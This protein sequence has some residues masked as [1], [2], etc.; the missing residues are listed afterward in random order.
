MTARRQ[1]AEAC[2]LDVPLSAN[3]Y[4]EKSIVLFQEWR[5]GWLQAE[6]DI[7][8][9]NETVQFREPKACSNCGLTGMHADYCSA[10]QRR[11]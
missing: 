7:D 6:A 11:A 4:Q 5:K 10:G 1:G 9:E 2:R 3:P 8:A